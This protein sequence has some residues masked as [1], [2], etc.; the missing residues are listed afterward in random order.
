MSKRPP[1]VIWGA[2]GPALVVEDIITLQGQYEIVGYI[3]NRNPARRGEEFGGA[4]VLGG[5]EALDTLALRQVRSAIIAFAN[6][7]AKLQVSALLREKGFS[8]VSAIHP[9]ASIARTARIGAGTIVRAQAAVGPRTVIG[10]NCLIGYGAMISHD[11]VIAEA[12]HLSSGAILGG[13][14]RVGRASW[15]ALGATLLDDRALGANSTLGAGSVATRDIPDNV[16]AYGIPAK[17]V[18]ST[19]ASLP[20]E[21]SQ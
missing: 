10:E 3:D 20:A 13:G 14:S 17:V 1:L 2:T 19:P 11:C 18:R 8:L 16:V 15:I 5:E 6:G 9:S 21:E 7:N 4:T 12:C